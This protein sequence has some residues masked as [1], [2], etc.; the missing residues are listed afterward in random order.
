MNEGQIRAYTNHTNLPLAKSYHRTD[1]DRAAEIV[2]P[3]AARASRS[4]ARRLLV[5]A[6][7]KYWGRY[8]LAGAIQLLH[9][10]KG[11]AEHTRRKESAP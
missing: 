7:A 6:S 8:L 2:F 9:T 1:F 10:H 5:D 11:V 3:L 4:L